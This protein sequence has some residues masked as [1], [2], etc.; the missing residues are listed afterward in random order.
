MK[1]H[2]NREAD[3]QWTRKQGQ[4][5]AYQVA[6]QLLMRGI[7]VFFPAVD[8]GADLIT[9][10]G[11]RIQVKS[12]YLSNR[13]T[14]PG[15]A[16]WFHFYKQVLDH[17]RR[18]NA[19]REFSKECDIVILWGVDHNKFWVVPACEL[20][21]CKCLVL[22]VVPYKNKH[23]IDNIRELYA[24][25]LTLQ[26]VADRVG[27]SFETVRRKVNGKNLTISRSMKVSRFENRWDLVQSHERLIEQPDLF[28]AGTASVAT[29]RPVIDEGGVKPSSRS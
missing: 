26:Q 9:E 20:D 13:G 1:A 5:G 12:T 23:D 22:G 3:R 2:I 8:V 17:G 24:S 21:K 11:L 28:T 29:H 18:R 6:S 4:A 19:V 14:Y 27:T 25:G 16:Y 10:S 7:N 15:G